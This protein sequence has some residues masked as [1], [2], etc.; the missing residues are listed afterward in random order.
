MVGEGRNPTKEHLLKL[1]TIGNITED[2]A[3]EI[4]NQVNTATKQWDA[5]AQE[6]GVSEVQIKNIGED[7]SRVYKNSGI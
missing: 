2:K 1:A 4:I 3:L 5:F 7:L 6:V